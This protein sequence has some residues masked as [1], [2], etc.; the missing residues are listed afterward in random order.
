MDIQ[1]SA[2]RV[3]VAA[4]LFATVALVLVSAV[5]S[6]MENEGEAV[7]P[8]LATVE[9]ELYS[10]R[11]NPRFTLT[12]TGTGEL[13]NRLALLSPTNELA[14]AEPLGYRGLRVETDA[15][16]ISEIHLFNGVIT[17]ERAEGAARRSDP[18]RELERWLIDVGAE[19]L[20]EEEVTFLHVELNR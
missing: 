9:V 4:L 11:E 3:T 13:I 5:G 7:G 8:E 15:A 17:V 16:G 10:G 14:A 18:G 12:A 2:A 20:A 6:S 19:Q 1:R